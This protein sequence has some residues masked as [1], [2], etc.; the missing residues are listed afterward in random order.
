MSTWRQSATTQPKG[1]CRA[2]L[3][4]FCALPS[5]GLSTKNRCFRWPGCNCQTQSGLS[6]TSLYLTILLISKKLLT[7]TTVSLLA[8]EKVDVYKVNNVPTRFPCSKSCRML[9][10]LF[11]SL[12]SNGRGRLALSSSLSC[13]VL[14]WR[15]IWAPS[16]SKIFPCA[17]REV[18]HTTT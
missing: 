8:L 15:P 11:S 3:T 2:G 13:K 10:S 17:K 18:F 1:Y 5:F 14:P 9:A 12:I 7:R 16:Q 6:G 4:L